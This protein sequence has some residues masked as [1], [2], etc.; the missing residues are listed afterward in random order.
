M[1]FGKKNRSADQVGGNEWFRSVHFVASG[2]RALSVSIPQST[3]IQH[4]QKPPSLRLKT[5]RRVPLS[6]QAFVSARHPATY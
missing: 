5:N 1:S 6:H 2:Q 3:L 4:R